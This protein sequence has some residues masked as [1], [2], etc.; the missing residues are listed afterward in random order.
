MKNLKLYTL[1]C[2]WGVLA[3]GCSKDE[4][5][6]YDENSPS[7]MFPSMGVQ[8]SKYPGY[9]SVTKKF[10]KVYSFWSDPDSSKV[11]IEIPMVI[12]GDVR[13]YDRIVNYEVDLDSCS[14]LDGSYRILDAV[15]PA[16]SAYGSISIELAKLPA[17]DSTTCVLELVLSGSAYFAQGPKDRIRMKFSWDNQ[18][19]MPPSNSSFYPRTY[20]YLINA[21]QSMTR[22]N[23]D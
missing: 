11:V 5:D 13:S 9:S 12:I 18:L 10:E 14:L 8:Q 1:I 4:I 23:Y 22:T 3:I 15:I 7:V 2:F 17:L 6:T 19:P 16:G 21:G 20:N